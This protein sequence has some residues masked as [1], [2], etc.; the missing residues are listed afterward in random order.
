MSA[1]DRVL[2]VDDQPEN[3]DLIEEVLAEEGFVVATAPDGLA[4]LRA[5]EE[6]QPDCVLLDVMMPGMDGFSVCRLSLIHISE[7][8]RPY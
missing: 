5:V 2:V 1:A 4:A 7:P 8:T 3:L 6:G